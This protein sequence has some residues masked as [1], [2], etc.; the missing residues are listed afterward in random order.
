MVDID[1]KGTLRD[2]MS[3]EDIS[4]STMYDCIGEDRYLV[5]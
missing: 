3:S 1:A 5:L 4:V 2:M